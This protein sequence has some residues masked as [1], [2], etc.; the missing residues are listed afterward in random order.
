MPIENT[1]ETRYN[2]F[3]GKTWDIYEKILLPIM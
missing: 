3:A 2:S 1:L